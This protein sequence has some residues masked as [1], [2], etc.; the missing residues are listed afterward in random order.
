MIPVEFELAL[1][2]VALYA[3]TCIAFVYADEGV[4]VRVFGGFDLRIADERIRI[5]GRSLLLLNPLTPMFPAFRGRWGDADAIAATSDLPV[6]VADACAASRALAPFVGAVALCVVLGLPAAL[7]SG[8]AVRAIPLALLAYITI[9]AMLLRLWFLRARFALDGRKF[10]LVAFESL[11]C[12]PFA[13]GI[14]RRL[15]LALPLEGDLA[16]YIPLLAS[17]RRVRADA[18]MESRCTEFA[19]FR[20]EDAPALARLEAYRAR[21]ATFAVPAS[22]DAPDNDGA[23]G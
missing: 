2:I 23:R 14:V 9:A 5:A 17:A 18:A 13:A 16:T 15:S 8:G 21:L 7:L 1:L 6:R 3:S 22:T 4:L 10:A 12:P 11:A 19:S 20:A